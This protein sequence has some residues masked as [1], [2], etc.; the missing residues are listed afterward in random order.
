MDFTIIIQKSTRLIGVPYLR[1]SL[2]WLP[3]CS[4]VYCLVQWADA[5]V[6]GLPLL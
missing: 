4:S 2:G 3:K 6:P 5:W 1:D